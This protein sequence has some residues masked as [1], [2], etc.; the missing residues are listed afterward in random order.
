MI[1]KSVLGKW[2]Y[3]CGVIAALGMAG[4]FAGCDRSDFEDSP[5]LQGRFVDSE[6][7][8]VE[9]E[10][11]TQSGVT[12]ENGEFSYRAGETIIFF[13]GGIILGEAE[14]EP[15]MTPVDLVEGA[16]DQFDDVVTNIARFLQTLDDDDDPDNGIRITE[17]VR[18][19]AIDISIDFN[20]TIVEFEENPDVQDA[21]EELTELRTAGVRLLALVYRVQMHL[22][23]TLADPE[24]AAEDDGEHGDQVEECVESPQDGTYTGTTDQGYSFSFTLENGQVTD[25]ET[26]MDYEDYQSDN[27]VGTNMLATGDIA[28]EVNDCA[29]SFSTNEVEIVGT[30]SGDTANGTWFY[31]NDNCGGAGDGT[32]EASIGEEPD[33]EEPVD[34]DNDGDG[35]SIEMD[36][37]DTDPTI[38]PG[39]MEI[40]GDGLDQDCDGSDLICVD[41]GDGSGTGDDAGN[42]VEVCH[43]GHTISISTSALQA[44][45]NHGDTEGPCEDAGDEAEDDESD[46]DDDSDDD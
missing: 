19:A 36:C 2:G 10:T 31:Q 17:E 8:G 22:A 43:N 28:V 34:E 37:D 15:V 29:F 4:M 38:F 11:E 35:V 13:I 14:A 16:T 42:K 26:K 30:I 32:W 39:A 41:G 23:M 33:D 27:C 7:E 1:R 18:N 40:C 20:V 5:V 45:L 21:V 46:E 9:Y 12:G 44:H 3:L 24:D 25:I 6:V